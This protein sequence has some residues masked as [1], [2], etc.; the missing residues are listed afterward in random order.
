[1]YTGEILISVSFKNPFLFL[2]QLTLDV[3]TYPLW[4]GVSPPL[5]DACLAVLELK[6]VVVLQVTS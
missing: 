1:M 6:E 5:V 4:K 2:L 3:R